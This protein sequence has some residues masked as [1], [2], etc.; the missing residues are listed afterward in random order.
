MSE[1]LSIRARITTRS[2]PF[3][4]LSALATTP[5]SIVHGSEVSKWASGI[6]VPQHKADRL[7][8]ALQSLE[9][10]LNAVTLPP[11]LRNPAVVRRALDRLP[12]LLAD[13]ARR[14]KEAAA[15]GPAIVRF[16]PEVSSEAHTVLAQDDV[17]PEKRQS[18]RLLDRAA[19]KA[20]SEVLSQ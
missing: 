13:K 7:E 1:P 3:A 2:I 18:K 6:K 14:E 8:G 19:A 5:T 20:A 10:L 12:E 9:K 4:T 11:D 15:A 17:A 16:V